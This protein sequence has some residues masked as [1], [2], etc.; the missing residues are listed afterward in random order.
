MKTV[1]NVWTTT[2]RPTLL[3]LLL[4]LSGCVGLNRGAPAPRHYVL[5]GEGPGTGAE[6]ASPAAE[7]TVIGL[8]PPR[9]AEYLTSPL[10]VVREGPHRIGFSEFHRWGEDLARGFNRTLVRRMAAQAPALRVASAPWSPT[11]QPEYVIQVHLLRFEGV[12][13]A[14]PLAPAGEAHL[15]ATWEILRPGDEAVLGS[16]TT[17]MRS[18]GWTVGDFDGLVSLLD[19][20]LDTLA[21]DLALGLER[22]VASAEAPGLP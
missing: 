21:E 22:V 7:G 17:E 13:A 20:G 5:G 11:A 18:R 8:R 1:T 6:A 9:L 16:G 12:T 4:S 3:F 14:A 10:I 15:L 19:A 2:A